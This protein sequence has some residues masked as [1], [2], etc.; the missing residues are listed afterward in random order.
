MDTCIFCKIVEGSAPS[1]KVLEDDF[2]YAFL[3]INPVS[4]YHTLIVPKKHYTNM[5][6]VPPEKA[7]QVMNMIKKVIDLYRKKLQLANCQVIS[8]NGREAQ[9]DVFHLHYHVVPRK[10]G[11][12]QNIQWRVHPEWRHRFDHLLQKLGNS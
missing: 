3:D 8:S 4:E 5:F 10:L 2:T 7:M 6:D 11:D 1:W 12:G 9:Q